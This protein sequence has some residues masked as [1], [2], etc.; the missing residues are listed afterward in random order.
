M[1]KTTQSILPSRRRSC[2][3]SSLLEGSVTPSAN[4]SALFSVAMSSHPFLNLQVF[5]LVL[6][7]T[8]QAVRRGANWRRRD[9]PAP[10]HS[11]CSESGVAQVLNDSRQHPPG[12]A[13]TLFHLTKR[14]GGLFDSTQLAPTVTCLTVSDT[15]MS[16]Q[17]AGVLRG[18]K[19]HRGHGQSHRVSLASAQH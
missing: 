9:Y 1:P 15:R 8:L 5:V 14:G 6:S 19:G 17:E 12:P 3:A 2:L 7:V 10:G 18:E 13:W 16:Q 11:P 4:V